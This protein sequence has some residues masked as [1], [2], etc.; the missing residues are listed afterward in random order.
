MNS[1]LTLV[2][3]SSAS[4]GWVLSAFFYGYM[5][6]QVPGGWVAT[7]F[8]GKHV[9]GMGVVMT[10]VLTL[11]TPLAADFSV[12]MLV[13]VR[14]LEGMFEVGYGLRAYLDFFGSYFCWC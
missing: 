13:A 6:T 14:V 4:T 10:S 12:W 3:C 8:G 1:S 9:F 5:F 7:R 11:L 2:S